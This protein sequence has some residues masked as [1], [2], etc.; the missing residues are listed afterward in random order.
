M[1]ER[2]DRA[3]GIGALMGEERSIIGMGLV[4]ASLMNRTEVPAAHLAKSASIADVVAAP[5]RATDM[6][7]SLMG[8]GALPNTKVDRQYSTT[9]NTPKTAHAFD[10][11]KTGVMAS[12]GTTKVN[13]AYADRMAKAAVAYDVAT[14]ARAMGIDLGFGI[15][16]YGSGRAAANKAGAPPT[17]K[18]IA[19]TFAAAAAIVGVDLPADALAE[20]SKHASPTD[21]SMAASTLSMVSS[22]DRAKDMRGLAEDSPKERA[23]QAMEAE[24]YG[25]TFPGV[26][27]NDVVQKTGFGAVDVPAFDD[28]KLGISP[29]GPM[30]FADQ[31]GITPTAD[32]YGLAAPDLPGPLTG[33]EGIAP[34]AVDP[35]MGITDGLY[36]PDV[37]SISQDQF[38][39]VFSAGFQGPAMGPDYSSITEGL[40][41]APAGWGQGFGAGLDPNLGIAAPDMPGPLTGL[42]APMQSYGQPMDMGIGIDPAY[43]AP[44]APDYGQPVDFSGSFPQGYSATDW[45]M[46]VDSPKEKSMSAMAADGT[47]DQR[48][49]LDGPA[50]AGFDSTEALT[51]RS[52]GYDNLATPSIGGFHQG[53]DAPSYGV[54]PDAMRNADAELQGIGLSVDRPDA[55]LVGKMEAEI[56]GRPAPAEGLFTGSPFASS[57][58]APAQATPQNPSTR[59]ETVK[60]TVMTTE[61]RTKDVPNPAYSEW[62]KN[63][64]VNNALQDAYLGDMKDK[65]DDNK[66]SKSVL[67]P[68]PPAPSKTI[69]QTYEVQVPKTV[70]RTVKVDVPAIAKQVDLPQTTVPSFGV[71]AP[72][73]PDFGAPASLGNP[74]SGAFGMGQMG[75]DGFLGGLHAGNPVANSAVDSLGLGYARDALL[76]AGPYAASVGYNDLSKA[77]GG[78][79]GLGQPQSI[80]GG[81]FGDLGL[82]RIA[83][84][85]R[86]AS[87]DGSSWGGYDSNAMSASVDALGGLGLDGFSGSFD[88]GFTSDG[89]MGGYGGY[90]DGGYG[91][92]Y[93]GGFGGDSGGYGGGGYGSSTDG[94]GAI[95]SNGSEGQGPAY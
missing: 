9:L 61:T 40:Y 26:N 7:N 18:E 55:G 68:A 45:G 16:N 15:T 90:G 32:P 21:I 33:L 36:G 81:F 64:G 44:A 29:L 83:D 76:S 74:L 2:L 70:E 56:S 60:D 39:D 25:P 53:F 85:A 47:F 71:A 50:I 38:N 3:F 11:F 67:G 5:H 6:L 77:F 17:A 89:S 82:N 57:Y 80:F 12:L 95:G 24:K 48:D 52:M 43:D 62:S 37:P 75:F 65:F 73:I 41:G 92:G 54:A 63:Y 42:D 91:G 93:G 22:L 58:S 19:A 10:A 31:F 1:S 69:S 72:S 4:A 51:G 27:Y 20:I 94:S 14:K 78:A 66:M 88:S 49:A 30:G 35:V 84:M 86:N 8:K 59:T 23:M 46:N 34:Q 28:N 79:F 13:P 87:N